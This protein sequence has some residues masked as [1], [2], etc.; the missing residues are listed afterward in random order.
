MPE[1]GPMGDGYPPCEN[2]AKSLRSVLTPPPR[3]WLKFYVQEECPD[4]NSVPVIDIGPANKA[5]LDL[6]QDDLV[7]YGHGVCWVNK[8]GVIE[9]VPLNVFKEPV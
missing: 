4:E 3:N 6:V 5:A 1:Y 8:N 7:A 9:A 2:L